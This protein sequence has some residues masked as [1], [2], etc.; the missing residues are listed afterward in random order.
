LTWL[1]RPTLAG[2][3]LQ[4]SGNLGALS[5]FAQ[6]LERSFEELS[7]GLHKLGGVIERSCCR[8]QRFRLLAQHFPAL[9][10]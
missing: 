2:A 8:V 6:D 4:S 10:E 3:S 7:L 1:A 9:I 5:G